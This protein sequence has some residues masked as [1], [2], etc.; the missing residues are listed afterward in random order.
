[1]VW[2]WQIHSGVQIGETGPW[3]RQFPFRIVD[4]GGYLQAL[5]A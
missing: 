1:M 3:L 5:G 2:S 4:I